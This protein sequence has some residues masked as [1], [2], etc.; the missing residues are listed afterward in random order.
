[1]SMLK[2]YKVGGYIQCLALIL[3]IAGFVLVMIAGTNATYPLTGLGMVA[4]QCVIGCVLIVAAM[5]APLRMGNKDIVS[6]ICLLVA[7]GLFTFVIGTAVN[8]RILMISGLFSWNT[9]D[10][11]GWTVFY[12]TIACAVC[13]A[14][15]ILCMIVSAFM[16]TVK[17]E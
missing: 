17:E 14:L 4:A 3:G 7:I 2:K 10:A 13:L 12:L 9:A 1:M 11:P 16:D 8:G 5:I 6:T 15:S